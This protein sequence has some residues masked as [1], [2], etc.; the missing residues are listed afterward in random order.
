M[1]KKNICIYIRN[2]TYTNREVSSMREEEF[3]QQ[4]L[5]PPLLGNAQFTSRNQLSLKMF[6][7]NITIKGLD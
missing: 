4:G 3:P 2:P 1:A 5:D 7:D 6:P